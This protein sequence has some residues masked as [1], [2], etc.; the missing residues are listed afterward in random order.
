MHRVYVLN[1]GYECI[2]SC[3]L[4]R[5]LSLIE[6][7][8]AEV[9]KY[10][11]DVI[12]TV[13]EIIQ[14]PLI[15][16]IFRFVRAYNR[17]M[18]Y[19]NKLTWE[20]DDYICQYCGKHITDKND[21]TTDH[22]LP[23]SRGGKTTYEN[24]TTACSYCNKKKNNRTPAEANMFPLRKPFKPSMTKRMKEVMDEVKKLMIDAYK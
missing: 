15:I 7:K 19:S 23:K 4:N 24:M 3:S 9:V 1:S 12:H 13:S 16:K 22:V 14:V 18:K 17:K 8:K 5:A 6:Q 20:R 11:E 10:A 2:S 21:L